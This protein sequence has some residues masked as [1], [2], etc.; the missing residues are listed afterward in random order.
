MKEFLAA[1]D[2]E[3]GM[4]VAELDRPWL[5]T[6]FL[7]QGFLIESEQQ[8]AQLRGL[9]RIVLI[10]RERSESRHMRAPAATPRDPA[11]TSVASERPL[12]MVRQSAPT[13]FFQLLKLLKAYDSEAP[14]A[15]RGEAPVFA[16]SPSRTAVGGFGGGADESEPAERGG[17]WGWLRARA[18]RLRRRE[19]PADQVS[20]E[21]DEPTTDHPYPIDVPLEQELLAAAPIHAE[22]MLA[23]KDILR[24][25]ER[26]A[27][28]DLG[29]AREVVQD[30]MHSVTRHPDALLWLTRLKRTDRYTYDHALDCSTYMMVFARHLGLPQDRIAM[31]GMA[32]MLLDIG[33]LTLS[34]RL[35]AKTTAL[36]P[37]EYDLFKTHVE[38]AMK[39]LRADASIDPALVEVVALH[40]ERIDG[41]G[42]PRGLSG[43]AIGVFGE[44]A[45]IVDSFCAMTRH[46]SWR[47]AVSSQQGLE[48]LIGLRDERFSAG[49]ID[50]FVQ[51]IGIYPA[52]TLVELNSGEVAVV[53]AQNRIRRLKPRVMVL[54]A[55]D[56]TPNANPHTLDLLYDP[57]V[58]G[59]EETYRIVRSLPERAF[60][61]D[62]AQFYLA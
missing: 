12:T 52:G 45:G 18:R 40:H 50:Q 16:W 37:L 31:L 59:R 17:V 49:L 9:C 23:V 61:I 21:S 57:A 43:E 7:M 47:P 1:S 3:L 25:V 5:E 46:R 42:Y 38:S 27:P 62:P 53:V 6:P 55:S 39:I 14:A 22:A 44:M 13:D 26:Q 24:D 4:F 51:C 2:L 30:M 35:L 28:P 34:A 10:D 36:T 19:A 11:P 8:L 56:R 20:D 15:A 29:R 58:P 33:K 41:S 60:G 48:A 54:L 32:G